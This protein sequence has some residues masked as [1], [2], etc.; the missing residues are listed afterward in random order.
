MLEVVTDEEWARQSRE[1][2]GL[3][4]TI[5]D[6]WV[7]NRVAVLLGLPVDVDPV[8]VEGRRATV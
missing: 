2:Q 4:P 1:E 8:P 7:A 5:E 6:E 3:P